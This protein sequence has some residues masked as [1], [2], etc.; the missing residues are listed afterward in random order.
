MPTGKR[1]EDLHVWQ[2]ARE[3]VR[4]VY[5]DSGQLEFSRDFALKDQIRRA[6]VSVMSNIGEG[7]TISYLVK[8]HH[9]AV[10]EPTVE[11]KIDLSDLSY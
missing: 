1:F 3:L 9:S 2:A 8:P 4:M 11:Y 7:L 6:A 5:E 10:K